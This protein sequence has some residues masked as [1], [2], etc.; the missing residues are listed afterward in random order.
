M[1]DV[2]ADEIAL[3][4]EGWVAF[5]FAGPGSVGVVV[6]VTPFCEVVGEFETGRVG[7]GVFEVDDYQLLVVVCR[8]H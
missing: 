6:V 1:I 2:G 7:G 5:C 4:L 8:E 3:L